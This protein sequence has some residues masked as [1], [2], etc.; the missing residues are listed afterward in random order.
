M[1]MK[2]IR[3]EYIQNER[4]ILSEKENEQTSGSGYFYAKNRMKWSK[5][6]PNN[7]VMT[8]C[9]NIIIHLPGLEGPSKLLGNKSEDLNIPSLLFS[10]ETLE[11]II[12]VILTNE[13]IEMSRQLYKHQDR[14]EQTSS[15]NQWQRKGRFQIYNAYMRSSREE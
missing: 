12:T 2:T 6:A 15:C 13:K 1:K 3:K 7:K 8:R 5:R 11:E 10:D 9:D 14:T 4:E